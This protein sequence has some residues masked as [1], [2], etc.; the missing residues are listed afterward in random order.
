MNLCLCVGERLR[1]SDQLNMAEERDP[2]KLGG[3]SAQIRT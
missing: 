1:F 3:H 2:V